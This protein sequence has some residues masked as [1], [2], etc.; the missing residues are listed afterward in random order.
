[1]LCVRCSRLESA[2]MGNE[3]IMNKAPETLGA[4]YGADVEMFEPTEPSPP[5]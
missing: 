5:T 1:M 2:W 3:N 4:L